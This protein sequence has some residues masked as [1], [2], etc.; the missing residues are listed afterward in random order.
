MDMEDSNV[1]NKLAHFHSALA[2]V[3]P[4]PV[5]PV[6]PPPESSTLVY[7][8]VGSAK[9]DTLFRQLNDAAKR[10]QNPRTFI[11]YTWR[12]FRFLP[13]G[14]CQSNM[15][16]FP[17][18]SVRLTVDSEYKWRLDS[19][20][21]VDS[22][23]P[24]GGAFSLLATY[25]LVDG[26][27]VVLQDLLFEAGY[28]P[29]SNREIVVG[30]MSSKLDHKQLHF[31]STAQ[32]KDA[33]NN[34][35][36][37]PRVHT[38]ANVRNLFIYNSNTRALLNPV[39]FFLFLV[40]VTPSQEKVILRSLSGITLHL[41]G[42][43]FATLEAIQENILRVIRPAIAREFQE[44]SRGIAL[45]Q[46]MEPAVEPQPQMNLSVSQGAD[47]AASYAPPPPPP[48]QCP[49]G[50]VPAQGSHPQSAPRCVP[51][52]SHHSN[53]P[54]TVGAEPPPP[55]LNTLPPYI[56]EAIKTQAENLVKDPNLSQLQLSREKS[57]V[58][59]MESHVAQLVCKEDELRAKRMDLKNRE[60]NLKTIMR[61]DPR[62][63]ETAKQ[64]LQ[65]LHQYMISCQG[66]ATK[67][68]EELQELSQFLDGSSTPA[69][70]QPLHQSTPYHP[71]PHPHFSRSSVTAGTAPLSSTHQVSHPFPP[72]TA[73]GQQKQT[74]PDNNSSALL[75]EQEMAR[76]MIESQNAA[77]EAARRMMQEEREKLAAAKAASGHGTMSHGLTREQQAKSGAISKDSHPPLRRPKGTVQHQQQDQTGLQDQQPLLQ[78]GQ[79]DH[80]PAPGGQPT[81]QD[82]NTVSVSSHAAGVPPDMVTHTSGANTQAVSSAP[83]T[84]VQSTSQPHPNSQP[85]ET[86]LRQ[87]QGFKQ[88][89]L[90]AH[91]PP[92]TP[93]SVYQT[94]MA[95]G[96]HVALPPD[97][98]FDEEENPYG[99]AGPPAPIPF[100]LRSGYYSG[101]KPPPAR[102]APA[103]TQPFYYSNFSPDIPSLQQF[104]YGPQYSENNSVQ[105]FGGSKLAP[106]AQSEQAQ[107]SM[108]MVQDFT[109]KLI[110]GPHSQSNQSS[111]I[112]YIKPRLTFGRSNVN[113]T[114][115]SLAPSPI[116]SPLPDEQPSK[117]GSKQ[118]YEVEGREESIDA[119]SPWKTVDKKGKVSHVTD[120]ANP[121]PEET[122]PHSSQRNYPPPHQNTRSAPTSPLGTLNEVRTEQEVLD[123]N[124]E[125]ARASSF[126]SSLT[127]STRKQ[128]KKVG[129]LYVNAKFA[130]FDKKETPSDNNDDKDNSKPK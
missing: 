101:Y 21:V 10:I 85:M 25:E 27:D 81:E 87:T 52:S 7:L 4:R 56:E 116:P 8:D 86:V 119:T 126:N 94:P 80:T 50:Y 9:A 95:D 34:D 45:R 117:I 32:E 69:V 13:I 111:D 89:R 14:V 70:R 33:F 46:L 127:N 41:G 123:N 90:F 99:N 53:P 66:E 109:N 107:M 17:R 6:T 98:S 121:T 115:P 71:P 49:P 54:A 118:A 74:R 75:K 120:P 102:P 15:R 124:E 2:S 104:N 88:N 16:I 105:M 55:P 65:H 47:Q 20:R 72:A 67:I 48:P 122:P 78:Q 125:M 96:Q 112:S 57:Y 83:G 68:T 108:S 63:A 22:M 91:Y 73:S 42:D 97:P 31:L 128:E 76:E 36:L 29:L 103:T 24:K 18:Q 77:R 106:L 58:E 79:A 61:T 43:N 130:L 37:R 110:V 35:Q 26:W 11:N 59:M 19:M 113:T 1:N 60:Q 93:A 39:S 62:Q 23:N 64:E 100:Y 114:D 28:Q 84:P 5:E 38:V 30:E 44:R 92:D 12:S 3:R 129:G 40:W 82:T 51:Q